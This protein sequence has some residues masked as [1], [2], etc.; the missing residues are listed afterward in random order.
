MTVLLLASLGFTVIILVLYSF[1]WHHF[2][3]YYNL[4]GGR[5]VRPALLSAA[6]G[7]SPLNQSQ[8]GEVSPTINNP[9]LHSSS[10]HDSSRIEDEEV[11]IELRN[12]Y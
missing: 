7:Y 11:T 9:L 2:H 12:R 4:S 3:N 6:G 10:S 5:M 1:V 8:R